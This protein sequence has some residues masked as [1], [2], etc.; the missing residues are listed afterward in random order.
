MTVSITATIV[1]VVKGVCHEFVDFGKS[2][3]DQRE[4]PDPTGNPYPWITV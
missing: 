3:I 2:F 1:L 4:F